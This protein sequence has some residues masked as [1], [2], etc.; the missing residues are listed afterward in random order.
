M[1]EN[2]N[3]NE[4][5]VQKLKH[6]SYHSSNNYVLVRPFFVKTRRISNIKYLKIGCS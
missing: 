1:D 2:E 3:V 4:S 6:R 5:V